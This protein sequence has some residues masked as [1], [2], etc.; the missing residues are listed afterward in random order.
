[1]GYE[2]VMK[3][4][5]K[6]GSILVGGTT[7]SLEDCNGHLWSIAAG[8]NC[9]MACAKSSSD[10]LGG[11]FHFSEFEPGFGAELLVARHARV[12]ILGAP[13]ARPFLWYVPL[14]SQ[15]LSVSQDGKP[16]CSAFGPKFNT[17]PLRLG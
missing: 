11:A 17:D 10:I 5:V 15:A 12:D 9:P 14:E 4:A 8:G 1:M 6:V 3:G 16:T 7:C 13:V 2:V